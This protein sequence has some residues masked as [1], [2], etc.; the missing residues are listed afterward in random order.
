MF[1]QKDERGH[2]Y[3]LAKKIASIQDPESLNE[4]LAQII[5]KVPSEQI[6]SS[7]DATRKQDHTHAIS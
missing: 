2:I 6:L 4:L 1:D 5:K 3:R 7:L